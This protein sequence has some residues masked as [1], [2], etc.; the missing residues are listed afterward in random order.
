MWDEHSSLC[1]WYFSPNTEQPLVMNV[2]FDPHEFR[3]NKCKVNISIF[4][5][6]LLVC[7]TFY[8]YL[9]VPNQKLMSHSNSTSKPNYENFKNKKAWNMIVGLSGAGGNECFF[10]V[11]TSLLLS[12]HLLEVHYCLY[13]LRSGPFLLSFAASH[14]LY[15]APGWVRCLCGTQMDVLFDSP[16][17]PV[18]PHCASGFRDAPQMWIDR[19]CRGIAP[20]NKKV[21]NNKYLWASLL[22]VMLC[23]VLL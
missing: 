16:A 14:L 23:Y 22:Q 8:T 12:N 15:K 6:R 2:F 18:S 5:R 20:D 19:I 10:S 1:V 7:K 17:V 13:S 11:P 9:C 3:V 21:P 4:V